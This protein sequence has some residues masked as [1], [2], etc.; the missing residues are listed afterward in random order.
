VRVI[1][2]FCPS[3]ECGVT[4]RTTVAPAPPPGPGSVAA[5]VKC[6]SCGIRFG[7]WVPVSQAKFVRTTERAEPLGFALPPRPR[8]RPLLLAKR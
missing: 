1:E 4:L 2:H 8:S 5:P 7:L 6:P 3:P